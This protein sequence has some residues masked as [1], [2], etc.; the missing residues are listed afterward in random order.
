MKNNPDKGKPMTARRAAALKRE[1]RKRDAFAKVRAPLTAAVPT[2]EGVILNEMRKIAKVD[3]CVELARYAIAHQYTEAEYVA[4]INTAA[5]RFKFSEVVSNK[6][7]NA[8]RDAKQGINHG[9]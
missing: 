9:R 5:R 1:A 7:R 8:Y 6:L 2:V 3:P 4:L